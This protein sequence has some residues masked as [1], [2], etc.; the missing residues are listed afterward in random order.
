MIFTLNEIRITGVTRS[1]EQARDIKHSSET[2]SCDEQEEAAQ[3]QHAGCS[4]QPGI[5]REPDSL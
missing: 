2:A 5:D 4:S 1:D 3:P